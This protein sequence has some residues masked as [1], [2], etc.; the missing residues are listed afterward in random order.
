MGLEGNYNA[1]GY[2]NLNNQSG[3]TFKVI[4]IVLIFI[5]LI[6]SFI[7]GV[8]YLTGLVKEKTNDINLGGNENVYNCS[9]DIY[10]CTNFTTQI[11]AQKIYDYCK[12]HGAGDINQLDSNN[13]GKA[14][15]D[16]N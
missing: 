11:E 10:N 16:L 14:C 6:G 4:L 5:I 9:A 3:K 12:N 8:N 13:D 2:E 15:E 7:L 1:Y